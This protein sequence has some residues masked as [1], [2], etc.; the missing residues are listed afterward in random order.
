MPTPAIPAAL[1]I[2]LAVSACSGADDQPGTVS[3]DEA[4]QLNEAAAM[5]DANSVDPALL[6]TQDTA[7]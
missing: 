2:L 6:N 5:L 1:A 4:R 7:R 3:A